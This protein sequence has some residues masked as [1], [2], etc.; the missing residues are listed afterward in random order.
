MGMHE[1]IYA[2]GS[3]RR[4]RLES[5]QATSVSTVS[6]PSGTWCDRPERELRPAVE[7]GREGGRGEGP[8]RADPCGRAIAAALGGG[9]KITQSGSAGWRRL[10]ERLGMTISTVRKRRD[11]ARAGAVP[12]DVVTDRRSSGTRSY[13]AARPEVW[14]ALE[15]L[16]DP[17]HAGVIR[18]RLVTPRSG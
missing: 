9:E 11:E 10:L 8:T 12:A 14:A 5:R 2:Y 4:M 18:N 7:G 3:S 16:M 17:L 15:K 6:F 1:V 13:E